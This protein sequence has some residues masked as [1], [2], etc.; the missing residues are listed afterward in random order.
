MQQFKGLVRPIYRTARTQFDRLRLKQQIRR[1]PRPLRVV[2]GAGHH[3]PSGWV[4]T[5]IHQL[6]LLLP[7]DWDFYFAERPITALLAEHVWEHL[8]LD[9]GLLAAQNCFRYLHPG[10]YLRVAV[11]DGLH[12][13]PAYREHVR[14]GGTGPGADDHKIFYT[15]R[16]IGE[17]FARAGFTVKP[18]EY[19]DEQGNF[20][21]L[22]WQAADGMIRR[23]FHFDR[24]NQP[25]HPI[26]AYT[27][28]LIDVHKD[29][30]A[31][32]AKE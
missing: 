25:G 1:T 4:G 9:E 11:P 24:R 22:P 19:F 26:P 14:P 17:L 3:C 20:H 2:V 23:S 29:G 7:A 28:L 5:N 32:P 30:A 10:G 18:L 15:Y 12:P 21:H 27:S 31:S 8:T 13:D 6:N 16:S